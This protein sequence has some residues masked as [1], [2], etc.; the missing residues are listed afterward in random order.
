MFQEIREITGKPIVNTVVPK[1]KII[2]EEIENDRIIKSW[3]EY[4]EELHMNGPEME[5]EFLEYSFH[6]EPNAIKCEVVKLWKTERNAIGTDELQMQLLT[7]K[8]VRKQ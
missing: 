6:E 5:R 3:K 2:K 7:N 1:S 8:L 4:T